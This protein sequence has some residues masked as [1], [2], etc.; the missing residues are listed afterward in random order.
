MCT[1][2]KEEDI[3]QNDHPFFVTDP[4]SNVASPEKKQYSTKRAGKQRT[5]M[6]RGGG[7]VQGTMTEWQLAKLPSFL[8]ANARSKATK[9]I[10]YG[11]VSFE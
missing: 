3:A 2:A 7:E 6:I 10:P 5:A 11:P 8:K 1:P 4:T 9:K